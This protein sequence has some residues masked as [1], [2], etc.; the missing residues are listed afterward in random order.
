MCS[1]KLQEK[2]E[3]FLKDRTLNGIVIDTDTYL[4]T[5]EYNSF[6]DKDTNYLCCVFC[7]IDY[8][9]IV[10][11]DVSKLINNLCIY[12]N[13]EKRIV[14]NMINDLF[15]SYSKTTNIFIND[16][17]NII[18]QKYNLEKMCT[19]LYVS[20]YTFEINNLY[21]LMI[22]IF[23][24]Y[25]VFNKAEKK[26]SI[27]SLFNREYHRIFE[28]IL[29]EH[30]ENRMFWL[31]GFIYDNRIME[32]VPDIF[33]ENKEFVR[34]VISINHRLF[35]MSDLSKNDYLYCLE[36]NPLIYS[37][38]PK[39]LKNIFTLWIALS[40]KYPFTEDE[41][42]YRNE[43]RVCFIKQSI[44]LYFDKN[45]TCEICRNYTFKKEKKAYVVDSIYITSKSFTCG[46]CE[47]TH[48]SFFNLLTKKKECRF[49]IPYIFLD[50][51]AIILKNLINLFLICVKKY[52]NFDYMIMFSNIGSFLLKD[53]EFIDM[54]IFKFYLIH[55]NYLKKKLF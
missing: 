20:K 55:S 43:M 33:K 48:K 35:E 47:G 42:K 44:K 51:N 52:K 10:I 38:L 50:T 30:F 49:D 21:P 2:Y 15:Y 7:I 25:M 23:W 29:S 9:K 4:F 45:N 27:Y 17:R 18:Q 19:L 22:H 12:K 53:L 36:K 54:N 34:D 40:Q 31:I 39:K 16:N 24:K 5:Q 26:V 46:T 32:L 13:L 37:Y 6:L 14:K 3:L 41:K 1:C 11:K 8:L 28:S